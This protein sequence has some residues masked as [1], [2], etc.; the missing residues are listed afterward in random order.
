M[1]DTLGVKAGDGVKH[2]GSCLLRVDSILRH[3]VVVECKATH[4]YIK[5]KKDIVYIHCILV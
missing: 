1:S 3:Y 5:Q 4:R 2:D